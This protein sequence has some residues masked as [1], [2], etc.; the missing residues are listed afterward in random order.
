MKKPYMRQT[1]NGQWVCRSPNFTGRAMSPH[2]AYIR[3]LHELRTQGRVDTIRYPHTGESPR[4][5]L[6]HD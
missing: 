1:P 6:V 5:A 2:L 4:R 3:W